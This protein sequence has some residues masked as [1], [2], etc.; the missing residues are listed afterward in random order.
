M[1]NCICCNSIM[2]EDMM[3]CPE[4]GVKYIKHD[5]AVYTAADSPAAIL[6]Q[7]LVISENADVKAGVT[8]I[9]LSEKTISACKITLKCQDAFGDAV[10][11]TVI[12]LTDLQ[13]DQQEVFG[14]DGAVRPADRGTRSFSAVIDK[15]MFDDGTAWDGSGA[16]F[17]PDERYAGLGQM[18]SAQRD[19][20]HY[21]DIWE[22][23]VQS[24]AMLEEITAIRIQ[25]REKKDA[26]F[27]QWMEEDNTTKRSLL[28]EQYEDYKKKAEDEEA[29]LSK[30][31]GEYVK[32][33][34]DAFSAAPDV[35]IPEGTTSVP[36]DLFGRVMSIHSIRFPDSVTELSG[37][38]SRCSAEVIFLPDTLKK[39]PY[40]LF[41]SCSELTEL[42]IPASVTEITELPK[43]GD[44]A[45][46]Q[47][48]RSDMAIVLRPFPNS[49]LKSL[50]VPDIF[51]Q[52]IL[53][54]HAKYNIEWIPP[55]GC[56]VMTHSGLNYTEAMQAAAAIIKERG[57]LESER[58]DLE[59]RIRQLKEKRGDEAALPS[60]AKKQALEKEIADLQARQGSLGIFKG[61]EKK[62][63]QEQIETLSAQI[64]TLN[65][66]IEQERQ[67][68]IAEVDAEIAPIEQAVRE[69]TE[70]IKALQSR[71]DGL[72]SGNL[73]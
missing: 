31:W 33:I 6:E 38:F 22:R 16:Q 12:K 68:H 7:N 66:A 21:R 58:D 67:Q 35:V 57:G 32:V 53:Q 73:H 56:T 71:I 10:S 61:R 29:R 49:K 43:R 47:E 48:S 2:E 4:C 14:T 28:G 51:L 63:L 46:Y 60:G 5:T 25:M 69:K 41:A 17:A 15:I 39:M 23:A 59:R 45:R 36:L 19:D 18:I 26:L 11:D 65:T 27:R 62:A 3:F 55:E 34:Q 72:K 37:S 8:L 50:T 52:T 24:E 20:A 30:A 40:Y 54:Q 1:R 64:P 9:S 13:I 42:T 70:Q 44:I